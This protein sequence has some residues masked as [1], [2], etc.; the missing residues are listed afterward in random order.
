[1]PRDGGRTIAARHGRAHHQAVRR[2]RRVAGLVVLAIVALVTLLLT[3]FGAGKS[4]ARQTTVGPAPANR[5]LPSGPPSPQVVAL[6]GALRI[7][8]PI[9][10]SRVTVI[11]YHAS[12]D[13]AVALQPLGSQAN[14]GALTRL[15]RSVFGGGSRGIRWFQLSGGEGPGTAALDVGALPGT[16]VYSPVDGSVIG[17]TP[18]IVNGKRFGSEIDVQ[19]TGAPSFVVSITHVKP[20]PTLTVGSSIAAGTS[21]LGVLLDFSRVEEQALARYTQDAGN[22]AEIEVRPAAALSTP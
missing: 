19:P 14:P 1:M 21:K 13:G 3:A 9:A 20:D 8:L 15:A 11:G 22:H 18:Y 12:G 17:L 10:Q 5:L 6:E 16:D 7:Q 2:R 4:P